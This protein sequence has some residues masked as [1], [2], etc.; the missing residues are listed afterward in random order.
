V[1]SISPPSTTSFPATT[2]VQ[3]YLQ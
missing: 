2:A 3:T 1:E